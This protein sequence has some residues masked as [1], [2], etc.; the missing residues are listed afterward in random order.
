LFVG[1]DIFGREQCLY[2]TFWCL[3]YLNLR[4]CVAHALGL[5]GSYRCCFLLLC[6]VGLAYDYNV[7]FQSISDLNVSIFHYLLWQRV[8]LNTNGQWIINLASVDSCLTMGLL[9]A[10]LWSL[11]STEGIVES[12]KYGRTKTSVLNGTD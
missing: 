2:L 6:L 9:L 8:T 11:F 5:S 3:D 12:N 4:F 10:K 1:C 7:A